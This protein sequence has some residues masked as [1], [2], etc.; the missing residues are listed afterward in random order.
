MIFHQGAKKTILL[1]NHGETSLEI[2][3]AKVSGNQ[4]SCIAQLRRL[5]VQLSETG[6]LKSPD[7]FR[8]EGDD[9]YAVRGRCGLR[10]YGWFD[11][12]SSTGRALFVVGHCVL[13]KKKKL[14]PA[15]LDRVVNERKKFR[16]GRDE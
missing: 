5:L 11:N 3:E 14:N 13:K 15:D 4:K 8:N 10:A 9:I 16:E 1:T 7:Q 6:K 12:D 2:A